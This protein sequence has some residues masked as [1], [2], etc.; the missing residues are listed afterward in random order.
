M[1]AVRLRDGR[2][3]LHSPTW[4]GDDTFER[5]EAIGPP[6]V[7]FA[8]NHFHHLGLKRF[9]A[10]YPGAL[11]VASREAL[12]RLQAKGHQGL[13]E[14]AEAE[15]LLPEGARFL[16]CEGV[17]SGEAWLS[18]IDEGQ[19]TLLASDAFFNVVQPVTGLAGFML[20][21][22]AIVPGLQIGATFIWLAIGDRRAYRAWAR[23]TLARE[24]PVR[25]ALSHG[26]PIEA[27]DLGDRL[28]TL[29]ERRLGRG[30]R[31][32]PGSRLGHER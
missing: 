21:R 13:R 5:L 31:A 32:G 16:R 4:V 12:P 19:R 20:R 18:L 27:P 29:I 9:R 25:L 3:L 2:T 22:M 23:E 28:A 8:P 30:R 14:L 10:R 17:R 24:A 11:V 15:P 7:L 26:E 6:G 1:Y